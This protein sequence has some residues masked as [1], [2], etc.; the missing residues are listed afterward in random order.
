MTITGVNT[1]TNQSKTLKIKYND[2]MQCYLC[3]DFN[4]LYSCRA[5]F[6]IIFHRIYN[7]PDFVRHTKMGYKAQN[8]LKLKISQ[9]VYKAFIFKYYAL[10]NSLPEE[11]LR[12]HKIIYNYLQNKTKTI[13]C[14]RYAL[15]V[16]KFLKQDILQNP[17]ILNFIETPMPNR[18]C[19]SDITLLSDPKW[20]SYISKSQWKI[21]SKNVKYKLPNLILDKKFDKLDSNKNYTKSE[22]IFIFNTIT[23]MGRSDLKGGLSF[24]NNITNKDLKLG[25]KTMKQLGMISNDRLNFSNLRDL[26]QYIQDAEPNFAYYKGTMKN[27]LDKIRRWH[28]EQEQIYYTKF[29]LDLEK[30]EKVSTVAPSQDIIQLDKLPDNIRF[31]QNQREVVEEGRLMKHC[32]ASYKDYAA[33]GNIHLFH[34][35]YQNEHATAAVLPDGQIQ[36]V[37]GPKNKLNDACKYFHKT[38]KK[39]SKC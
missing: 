7:E 9:S 2:K 26:R 22:L 3:D 10:L 18:S 39:L 8:K 35:N 5:I 37:Y 23:R 11:E 16:N 29:K 32:V 6:N 20:R 27:L 1:V 15:S 38:W 36:Q 28:Y 12:F 17:F 13:T 21:L 4:F 14:L 31:L 19:Y 33:K 34:V 25:L 24:L 30:L